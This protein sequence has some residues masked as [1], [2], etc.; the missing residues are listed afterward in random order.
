MIV[1]TR[2]QWTEIFEKIKSE[3]PPST[4][5]IRSNMRERLGFTL[6]EHTPWIQTYKDGDPGPHGFYGKVQF[7]LDFYNDSAES[8][9][10]L[11]Y[12]N[13]D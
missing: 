8:W 6:R 7:C 4:Y 10:R 9:F 12:L 11:K 13:R 1:L 2:T 3:Y 5:L